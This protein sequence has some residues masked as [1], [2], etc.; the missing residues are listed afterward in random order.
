MTQ[1][2]ILDCRFS[3]GRSG[4]KKI[5]YLTLYAMLF[6]LCSPIEAQQPGKVFRIGF[7]RFGDESSSRRQYET[8]RQTLHELG[9]VDGKN[10]V[11]E[12]RQTVNRLKEFAAELV[13]LKCDLIVANDTQAVLAAKHASS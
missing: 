8:I 3:I 6:A 1:F 10:V 9:Y 5:F 7:L 12:Y 4:C 13:R 11:F 2:S